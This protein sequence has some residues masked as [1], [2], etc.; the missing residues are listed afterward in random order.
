MD[1]QK[2]SE[3]S[4][5]F[6]VED[7]VQPNPAHSTLRYVTFLLSG[8]HPHSK[9]AFFV[10]VPSLPCATISMGRIGAVGELCTVAAK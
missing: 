4:L 7:S 3:H 10:A 2:Q 9:C 1:A 6:V 8:S 5:Y